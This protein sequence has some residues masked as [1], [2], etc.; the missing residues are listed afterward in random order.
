M[1]REI[2]YTWR[3]REVMA[4][5]GIHT[6]KELTELLHQ[7]GIT[8]TA[9]AVWRIVTQQPERISFQVL[10]ALCDVLEVTPN[11]LITYTATDTKTLRDRRT[12]AGEP[13]APLQNY[14]PVRARIVDDD[15]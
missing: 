2:T 4:R 5:R 8:L 15:D 3:V 6:A 9:N 13:I 1:R 11:E 12:A 14:R 7:R 10:V